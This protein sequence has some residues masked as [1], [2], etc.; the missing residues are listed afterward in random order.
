MAR[1]VFLLDDG[2]EDGEFRVPLERFTAAGDN[3]VVVGVEAGRAVTGKRGQ[4]HAQ[5][6]QTP[7]ECNPNEIGAV[8]VPGGWSP[9]RLRTHDD[10]VALVRAAGIAGK[11]VAAIW[12]GPSLLLEADLVRGRRVTSWPSI[13]TDLVNAGA[14]GTTPT[15]SA[16]GTSLPRVGRTTYRH[17]VRPFSMPRRRRRAV[18]RRLV[19]VCA[20]QRSMS[21]PPPSPGRLR[22]TSTRKRHRTP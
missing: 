14:N 22:H 11:P 7:A 1:V 3:A 13:R 6:E 19:S 18:A 2:F 12:H 9:D 20:R 21:T 4:E 15:S 16:T 10:V 8:V 5:I 17:S